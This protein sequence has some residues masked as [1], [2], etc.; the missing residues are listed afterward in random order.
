MSLES[1]QVPSH[2]A[3][4]DASVDAGPDL[5]LYV[6]LPW[7]VRKC[8]YCD[9][10]S[11]PAPE[12][13]PAAQY[14]NAL[15]TDFSR[16]VQALS[17]R[18]FTSVFFGGGTPS[19]F[20]PSSIGR[21]LAAFDAS[22]QLAPDA[23][24]TLEANPGAIESKRFRGIRHAG[25]NRLSLG[26]QSFNDEHLRRLGRIHNGTAARAAVDLAAANFES[27]SI[28]LMYA[29]PQQTETEALTDVRLALAS[30]ASHIA[31]YQLTIEPNTVFHSAP[32]PLPS[33][34]Q[35]EAIEST[36]HSE[37]EAANFKRYEISNWARGAAACR[38]N[39]N[40]WQYG[41]Y[42]GIGAGAHS[43]LSIHGRVQREAR[44]RV[45][46]TY[47]QRVAENSH[48]AQRQWPAGEDRLFEYL[49]NAL[50]LSQGF[51]LTKMR[52]RIAYDTES[53][54]SKLAAAAD[55]GLLTIDDD[56]VWPTQRGLRYLNEII[57]DFLPESASRVD[58]PA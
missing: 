8:P 48:V 22:G 52:R 12:N 30:G 42:L 4:F 11:H 51:S 37:L 55:K 5:G 26:V 18:R 32:L 16:A 20:S 25:V 45:P 21:L 6:H 49:L 9:F 33:D 44:L 1:G 39:L 19:L 17:A 35:A 31:C 29:L 7:C 28:D 15:L 24:I 54:F 2:L 36:V 43:K 53:V 50:R 47:M 58:S 34:A 14:V 38:H 57:R 56:R 40:Y 27:F 10:N 46:A 41:D 23:E 3:A 13:I